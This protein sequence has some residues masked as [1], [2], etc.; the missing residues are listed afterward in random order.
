MES[1]MLGN[2]LVRFGWG[3]FVIAIRKTNSEIKTQI[4]YPYDNTLIEPFQKKLDNK[5]Y[6][7]LINISK[8][9]QIIIL[10]NGAPKRPKYRVI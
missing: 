10:S 3:L 2:L 5:I 9:F 6:N 7:L 8:Q 1:R 4:I